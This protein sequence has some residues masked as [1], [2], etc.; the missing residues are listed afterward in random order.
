MKEVLED[1]AAYHQWANKMLL[2][3]VLKLSDA[4]AVQEVAGSFPSLFKTFEHL[5]RAE[6][7]WMSRLEMREQPASQHTAPET[8]NQLAEQLSGQ[9][10]KMI[11]WINEQSEALL[12]HPLA[13][14]NTKKQYFK[15]P[16]YQCLLH[17]FNHGTYHRGQVVTMLRELGITTI[18]ATDYVVFLRKKKYK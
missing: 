18:P 13:Y 8:F 4:V 12:L 15:M 9:N 5:S 11:A 16:V 1:L 2:E 6:Q 14:Y 17:V 10:E 7:I 3:T